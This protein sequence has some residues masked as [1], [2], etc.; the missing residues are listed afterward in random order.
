MGRPEVAVGMWVGNIAGVA[1]GREHLEAVVRLRVAPHGSNPSHQRPPVTVTPGSDPV[2]QRFPVAAS[3]R[4][5][6]ATC[7]QLTACLWPTSEELLG[8]GGSLGF[9]SARGGGVGEGMA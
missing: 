3:P 7:R 2:K 1:V 8:F 6:Q 4:P 5:P 9:Q